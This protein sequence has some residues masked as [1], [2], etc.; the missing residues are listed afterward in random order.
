MSTVHDRLDEMCARVIREAS[1]AANRVI[2]EM[3]TFEEYT[4]PEQRRMGFRYTHK[5][6]S[7][8]EIRRVILPR[9]IR[10]LDELGA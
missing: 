10:E 2:A 9:A 7:N 8:W 3:E 5:P 6:W 1:D 4:W